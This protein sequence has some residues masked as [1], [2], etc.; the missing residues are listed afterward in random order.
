MR[1]LL[2]HHPAA[3]FPP[4]TQR[5]ASLGPTPQTAFLGGSLRVCVAT[6]AFGMGLDKPDLEAVLHTSM[7]HSLEEYVQQVGRGGR[8]GRPATCIAFLDPS[9][10]VRL[11]VLA[12]G[13]VAARS[14]VE[15]FLR[16]VFGREEEQAQEEEDDAAAAAVAAQQQRGRGTSTKKQARAIKP[17]QPLAPSQHRA[18][19]VVA[20]CAELD[21][22]EE[23]LESCLSFLQADAEEP[24]L[25]ALPHA[26]ATLDVRFH[27]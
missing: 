5:A 22:S 18:V 16:R 27:K 17:P 6:I 14:S 23:V 19:P 20:T 9:D 12:H 25:T 15:T 3:L 11:R 7:P 4:A 13:R 26:A 8:D 1:P 24:F 10:Y 21:V 2:P